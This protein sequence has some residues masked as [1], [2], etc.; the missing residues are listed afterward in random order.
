MNLQSLLENAHLDA[1]GLLDERELADYNFAFAAAPPAVQQQIHEEQAR[2]ANLD[3]L[4]PRV[5]PPAHLRARVLDRLSAEILRA[6]AGGDVSD[7]VYTMRPSKRVSPIWRL[8]AVSLIGVAGVLGAAFL[9]VVMFNAKLGDN[10][11]DDGVT[12][13]VLSIFDGDDARINQKL[14]DPSTLTSIFAAKDRAFTGVACISTHP[15]WETATLNMRNMPAIEGS[16]HLVL[17]DADNRIVQDV[18]NVGRGGTK[19][20]DTH[21]VGN[22]LLVPGVRIAIASVAS[23]ADFTTGEVVLSAKMG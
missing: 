17:V 16:Y 13:S 2:W 7:D 19:R 3:F 5:E 22:E 14:F 23:G 1:L 18:A 15:D 8:A 9:N 6:Q 11:T 21:K 12:R 10:M 4:L 20:I